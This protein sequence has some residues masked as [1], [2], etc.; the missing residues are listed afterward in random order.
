MRPILYLPLP[1]PEQFLLL[2]PR[3]MSVRVISTLRMLDAIRPVVE[4]KKTRPGLPAFLT[5]SF[6]ANRA[7]R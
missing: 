1:Y 5:L 3:A 4:H 7:A 2:A 6:A